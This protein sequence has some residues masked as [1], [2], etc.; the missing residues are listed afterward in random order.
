MAEI[1]QADRVYAKTDRYGKPESVLI[2]ASVASMID[3]F[4]IPNIRLLISLGYQ[5]DVAANFKNGNTCTR[6]RL[7]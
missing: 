5:V 2:V 7:K 3:Q 6:K 1:Q 4:N